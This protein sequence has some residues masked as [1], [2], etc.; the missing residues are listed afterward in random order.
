MNYFRLIFHLHFFSHLLP[1]GW[2]TEVCIIHTLQ[3]VFI[4]CFSKTL[5]KRSKT[6]R[7][8]VN[9]WLYSINSH[10]VFYIGFTIKCHS[11]TDEMCF[12]IFPSEVASP[13]PTIEYYWHRSAKF[14]TPFY[15]LTGCLCVCL[16][17]S[18]R[19]RYSPCFLIIFLH[20]TAKLRTHDKNTQVK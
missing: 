6:L 19:L 10:W 11:V 12:P 2:R 9:I 4:R 1:K 5:R 15:S 7:K 18:L 14:K 13:A 8:S 17:L 16:R 3:F 20:L